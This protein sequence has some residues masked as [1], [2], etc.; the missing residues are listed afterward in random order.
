MFQRPP[1]Y[2]MVAKQYSLSYS[3]TFE[4]LKLFLEMIEIFALVFLF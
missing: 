3:K 1:P 4:D 2:R